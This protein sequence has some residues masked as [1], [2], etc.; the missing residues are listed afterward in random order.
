MKP[1]GSFRHDCIRG[2]WNSNVLLTDLVLW[3]QRGRRWVKVDCKTIVSIW[4]SLLLTCQDAPSKQIEKILYSQ[5]NSFAF[6]CSTSLRLCTIFVTCCDNQQWSQHWD[7]LGAQQGRQCKLLGQP[8]HLR[9]ENKAKQRTTKI[10]RVWIQMSKRDSWSADNPS[11][12]INSNLL[13][14][15]LN[16]R[17]I[18]LILLIYLPAY[19]KDLVSV[20]V[21][22]CNCLCMCVRAPV[23]M[24]LSA[25]DKRKTKNI[26]YSYVLQPDAVKFVFLLLIS[27]F[28]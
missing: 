4:L 10:S 20:W 13:I 25:R 17:F 6:V 15:H 9:A 12:A 5:W 7:A 28:E 26:K 2:L 8:H 16:P 22:L 14:I 18:S 1:V 11:T 24:W 3:S 23:F 27:Q 21:R 19:W